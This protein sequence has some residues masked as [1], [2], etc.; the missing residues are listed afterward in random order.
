MLAGVET[1]YPDNGSSVTVGSV[2]LNSQH[3]RDQSYLSSKAHLARADV[4]S[5]IKKARTMRIFNRFDELS[6]K[7][8]YKS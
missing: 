5:V 7:K 4:F 6:D 3:F 1:C 2:N 8:E